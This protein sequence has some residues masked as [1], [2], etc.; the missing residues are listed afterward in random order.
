MI[1]SNYRLTSD[2]LLPNYLNFYPENSNKLN[3][4]KFLYFF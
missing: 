3:F 2:V 4:V 1:Y